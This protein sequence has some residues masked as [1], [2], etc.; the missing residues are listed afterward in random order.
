LLNRL[1]HDTRWNV[2]WRQLNSLG[3]LRNHLSSLTSQGKLV[4]S[5]RYVTFTFAE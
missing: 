4:H 1:Q 2:N 3:E 5:L